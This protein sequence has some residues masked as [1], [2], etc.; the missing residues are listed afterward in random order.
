MTERAIDQID[1]INPRDTRTLVEVL[2]NVRVFILIQDEFYRESYDRLW[3][4]TANT[5]GPN[6]PLLRINALADETPDWDLLRRIV[7][8]AQADK[9]DIL[10]LT[11]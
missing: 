1:G 9:I 7:T 6:A 10:V 4:Y 5:E 11:W 2:I 3:L 8:A